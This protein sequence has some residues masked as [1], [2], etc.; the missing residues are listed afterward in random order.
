MTEQRKAA[1]IAAINQQIASLREQITKADAETRLHI[2]KRDKLNEQYRKIHQEIHELKNE[3]NSLNEKVG[4][5]KLQRDNARAKIRTIIDEIKAHNQKSANLKKKTPKE[6]YGKLQK[7]FDDIEWK[8]QTTSL[9]MQEEKR[10]VAEAQELETQLNIYKKI[11]LQNKKIAEL[12]GQLRALEKNA[13]AFHQELTAIAQTSQ[14]LHASMVE[15]INESRKIKSEADSLHATY[16]QAK[17]T[18]KPIREE[19]KRLTEQKKRLLDA[20]REEDEKKKKMTERALKEKLEFQAR[21]KLQRGEKLSWD[22]FQLLVD[23]DD[24]ASETQD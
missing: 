17:E 12:R 7:K 21:D 18:A 24:Q 22:E 15:K 2:E 20:V 1:E 10:L 5:L 6:S 4:D 23:D 11:E 9:D 14:E 19:M 8:I 16:I 13:D 3:R